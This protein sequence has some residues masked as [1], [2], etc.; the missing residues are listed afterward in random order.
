ML[1]EDL[2]PHTAP[3]NLKDDIAAKASNGTRNSALA[4]M[5][6]SALVGSALVG[7]PPSGA[8][9]YAW[10]TGSLHTLAGGAYPV[11]A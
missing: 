2:W 8:V 5:Q 6:G 11:T 10:Q 3:A 4:N 9:P 1:M 7:P